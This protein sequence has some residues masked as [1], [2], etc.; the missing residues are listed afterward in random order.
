M[1][2]QLLG[3][4]LRQT[5]LLVK[6]VA[7]TVGLTSAVA[8]TLLALPGA[9]DW[10]DLKPK[11]ANELTAITGRTVSLEG[12]LFVEF[13]P[14]PTVT[15]DD[16]RIANAPGALAPSLL[17]VRRLSIRLSL[18]SLMGGR[19]EITR[20][21]LDQPQ[22]AIEPGA[23]GR[24]NWW[25][26]SLESGGAEGATVL[27]LTLDRL[28]VR[29]GRL[30][31]AVGLV[32]QP[33]EAQAIDFLVTLDSRTGHTHLEGSGI[34]NGLATK[35]S[36]DS[37]PARESRPP[38][39]VRADLPGGR[40]TFEGW[41]G[42]RSGT[43]PLRGRMTVAT[44]SPAK[45]ISSLA[46]MMGRPPVHLDEALLQQLD[47]SAD[48]SF[49]GWHF[50]IKQLAF[51]VDGVKID[52]DLD[53][54]YGD[55]TVVSG[56]L[57]A[58]TLDLDRWI[59][60]LRTHPLLARSETTAGSAPAALPVAP[61]LDL[62]VRIGE[63]RYRRD[64]VRNVVV[65]F[66]FDDGSLHV[67]EVVAVLPGDC[68]LY[69]RV[70]P[71]DQSRTDR[72]D[73]VDIETH[74]LRETLAWI[75]IE[76][77]SVPADRLQR[78]HLRGR[79]EVVEGAILVT[80][81]TFALDDQAGTGTARAAFAIPTTIS[82]QFQLPRLD[83]DSYRLTEQALHEI[84][85]STGESPRG[86]EDAVAPPKIDISVKVDQVKY[87]SEPVQGVEAQL[88]VQGNRLTLERVAVENLLGSRLEITGAVDDFATRPRLDLAW[89]GVLPDAD[90]VL[91]Y[92]GLP[93]F[94][95]GR[96]GAART[97]GHAIG[98]L[99]SVRLSEL[100]IDML[101]AKIE[102]VGHV[103][104]GETLSFDFTHLSLVTPDIGVLAAAASGA[105]HRSIAALSATGSFRGDA[106]R[107]A[108]KGE[109]TV[110]GM[111]MSGELS[112]TL[113]SHPTV[114]VALQTQQTLRLD[115]WLPAPPVPAA[116]YALPVSANDT[117]PE[118]EPNW[119][120]T[121]KRL[122]GSLSL[123][124][125]ALAWGPYEMTGFALSARLDKGL[126]TVE[127]FAGSLGGAT[128]RLSGTVDAQQ[129]PVALSVDGELRDVDVSRT[130]AGAQTA[131]DFGTDE[132]A[133][134]LKGKVSLEGVTLRARGATLQA[135]LPTLSGKGQ[136]TGVIQ[137][138]VTRGSLSMASL[139]T[140]IFSL[141]SSE[142]GFASAIIENFVGRWVNSRGTV[143]VSNGIVHVR[144]YLFEGENATAL[145]H[146]Q[147][148]ALNE[149]LDTRIE[150]NNKDGTIDY[151]M[152]LRGPLRT[153]E[154]KSHTPQGR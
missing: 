73:M 2:M 80:D 36:V 95:H 131:N 120:S 15:V 71:A 5:L 110:D 125:P 61:R 141:F 12:P 8:G 135:A 101:D 102:A 56:H 17:A 107:A 137:P 54:S 44:S 76:T 114:S 19:I 21:I 52:G 85:P 49:D 58:P 99:S 62:V 37:Y 47:A 89:Q 26:P 42:Q 94:T 27:P 121:L 106:R 3:W 78:L 34:V 81:A 108:F 16:A 113:D 46:Q 145:F 38:L 144:E 91:D 123:I 82:A 6:I 88:T 134:A 7:W 63:M 66:E 93:R 127:S 84:A 64:L 87:R 41:T 70:D 111:Q 154:L 39:V 55:A 98:T 57:S 119:P 116:G 138:V 151:S 30:L 115:R 147:I 142:M 32:D 126:L 67:R 79:T 122:D 68:R 24:P 75:G 100:S 65:A 13:L 48:V 90:R 59:A 43:D 20:I 53:V 146:G 124:A 149:A 118:G 97:A 18:K 112:S 143:E 136:A 60:R 130:I 129:V 74:R 139:A 133:V 86:Q 92:A 109:V 31:R 140:G 10:N 45:L 96:I 153:P 132:L 103:S 11:L 50:S 14:W 22:L 104:F 77:R 1:S 28:E 150:L 152:S 25:L 35:A 69:Y 40:L 23:N 148:D 128:F 117:M 83:L 72:P 51:A 9:I 29:N 4:C 33:L 105:A